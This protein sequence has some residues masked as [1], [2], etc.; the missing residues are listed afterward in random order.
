MATITRDAVMKNLDESVEFVMTAAQDVGFSP[1]TLNRVRLA[2]EEILVNVIHYAY[3]GKT[4]SLE[5]KVEK[6]VDRAG[7]R[8][9]VADSG[10]PFDPVESAREDPSGLPLEE[11]GIGGLGIQMVKSV[12]DE[13]R[14]RRIDGRNELTMVKYRE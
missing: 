7:L 1:L 2:A 5:I 4:G 3:P 11:R 10:I 6:T 8:I 12:M 9:V 13:M 14:Y